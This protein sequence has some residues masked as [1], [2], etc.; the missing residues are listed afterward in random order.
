MSNQ[1][2]T[3]SLYGTKWPFLDLLDELDDSANAFITKP[4]VVNDL[5]PNTYNGN[6]FYIYIVIVI[7]HFPEQI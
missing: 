1:V 6:N 7:Y 3:E 5:K 2:N 4:S